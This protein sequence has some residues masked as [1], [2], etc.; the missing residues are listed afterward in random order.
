MRRVVG[1]VV[2]ISLFL[3]LLTL[4]LLHLHP[5]ERHTLSAVVHCHMPHAAETHPG[6]DEADAILEDVDR[7]ELKALPFEISALCASA[8]AQAP[9]PEFS[10]KL[11]ML[12]RMGPDMPCVSFAEPDPRAKAPPGILNHPSFRSPP[13]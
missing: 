12:L 9:V 3:F 7:D 1:S 8:A 6:G 2:I 4:P 10:A 11:P 5:G 13:A